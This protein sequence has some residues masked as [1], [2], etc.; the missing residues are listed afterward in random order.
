MTETTQFIED[1]I[2]GGWYIDEEAEVHSTGLWWAGEL[3][4][5]IETILLDPKAWQAVGKTRGWS[6]EIRYG[7]CSHADCDGSGCPKSGTG[8][9][10]YHWHH[11][12]DALAEGKNVEEA[13]TAIK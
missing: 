8:D 2:K 6:Y 11:F 13:L 12:I 1:A 5:S 7:K 10:K 3:S 4:K 9:W